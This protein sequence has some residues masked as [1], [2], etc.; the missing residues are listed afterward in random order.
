MPRTLLHQLLEPPSCIIYRSESNFS[1]ITF[2]LKASFVHMLPN[3]RMFIAFSRD[4]SSLCKFKHLARWVTRIICWF[5]SG[6]SGGL[7]CLPDKVFLSE[8]SNL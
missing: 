7:F 3:I 1:V 8:T 6:W 4:A 5:K 2:E